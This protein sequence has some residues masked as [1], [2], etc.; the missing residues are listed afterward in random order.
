VPMDSSPKSSER[1]SFFTAPSRMSMTMR[2]TLTSIL[3]I[4]NIPERPPREPIESFCTEIVV[5]ILEDVHKKVQDSK[6]QLATM[7]GNIPPEN[8]GRG[9]FGT[10]FSGKDQAI[11]YKCYR[12]KGAFM[13]EAS[14]TRFLLRSDFRSWSPNLLQ[15]WQPKLFVL[16][17]K[18][19]EELYIGYMQMERLAFDLNAINTFDT[20]YADR[21]FRDV[22]SALLWLSQR[23][24]VHTD[25]KLPNVLCYNQMS[26]GQE[27]LRMKLGDVAGITIISH[28]RYHMFR[29]TLNCVSPQMLTNVVHINKNDRLSDTMRNLSN[30]LSETY[31]VYSCEYLRTE[32][33]WQ[34]GHMLLSM[35]N[36]RFRRL[37]LREDGWWKKLEQDLFRE[38]YG[39][40]NPILTAVGNAQCQEHAK[41]LLFQMLQFHSNDR[42][43]FE[44]LSIHLQRMCIV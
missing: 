41:D 13:Q 10:V 21:A 20:R 17:T 29:G 14:A 38:D 40:S 22:G 2:P 24:I 11:C 19:F 6:A 33:M 3:T 31:A 15:V 28:C 8:L 27:R 26:H 7:F 37:N 32:D 39:E 43:T 23:D 16:E 18:I 9:S 30:K 4:D 35:L 12:T 44:M 1:D 36:P 5:G 42:L 34:L 25:V